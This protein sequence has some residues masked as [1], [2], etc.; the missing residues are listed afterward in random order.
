MRSCTDS[1]FVNLGILDC[2]SPETGPSCGRGD[3]A[4]P[5]FFHLESACWRCCNAA[6]EPVRRTIANTDKLVQSVNKGYGDNTKFNRD[7]SRM[8]TQRRVQRY[9]QI[10]TTS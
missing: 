7:I 5:S 2:T 6:E 4:P 3:P 10:E 1:A 9:S 8:I